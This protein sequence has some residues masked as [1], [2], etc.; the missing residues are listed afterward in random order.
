MDNAY[1]PLQ[2][3]KKKSSA[4]NFL[5]TVNLLSSKQVRNHPDILTFLL[6]QST[7]ILQILC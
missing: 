2:L 1:T 6:P 3:K 5:K 7:K 4:C